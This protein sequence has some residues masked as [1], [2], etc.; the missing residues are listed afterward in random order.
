MERMMLA[1]DDTGDTATLQELGSLTLG[2]WLWA[3]ALVVG[4][5]IIGLII[6]RGLQRM[7]AASAGVFVARLV[8]RLVAFGIFA[9]GFV[10]AL[11]Q[12]GVSIAPL[13]GVLGIVGLALAFAF[14]DI[15]ENF[16]AGVL[17]SVRKPFGAGDQITTIGYSG[18]VEEIDLRAIQLR[19]YDGERV[20]IPNATVWKEP[21]ENHT[22]LGARRTRLDVG[23]NYHTDLERATQLIVDAVSG[24]DGVQADPPPEAF[25]HNFGDSSIDIAVR[26]W[27]QPESRNEWRVRDTVAKRIKQA[28]DEAGIGIPF[29][30]RVLHFATELTTRS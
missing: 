21:L 20:F 17:I 10:Y 16:L 4:A 18:V 22:L 5:L 3:G 27:H 19:T 30:Q 25:V 12:V 6:K 11:N 24:V 7:L 8:G 23:V 13:L 2:D 1:Q 28:L 15:L 14:Q 26:F 9:I 29:P